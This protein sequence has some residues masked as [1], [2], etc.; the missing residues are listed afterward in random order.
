MEDYVHLAHY[1]LSGRGGP[2][3]KGRKESIVR[4]G[5]GKRR[6]EAVS[7]IKK[8]ETTPRGNASYS[9]RAGKERKAI[10]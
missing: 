10:S 4:E 7:K 8:T 6:R 9:P 3:E 2:W 5:R 1:P